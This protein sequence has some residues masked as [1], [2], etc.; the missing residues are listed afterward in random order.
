MICEVSFFDA[1][2]GSA[3]GDTLDIFGR[4]K[5]KIGFLTEPVQAPWRDKGRG[6]PLPLG[7][8]GMIYQGLKGF[9]DQR[10]ER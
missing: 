3:P 6:K 2:F 5:V 8:E 7:I 1:I 9:R 4:R 10:H